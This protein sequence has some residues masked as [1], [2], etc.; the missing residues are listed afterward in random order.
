[1]NAPTLALLTRGL[2]VDSRAIWPYV[3]RSL[4]L[5]GITMS[6]LL[7]A[8]RM[9]YVSAAG[10]YFLTSVVYFTFV[11]VSLTAG[12]SFATLLT[13]E[14]EENTLGLLKMAGLGPLAI[15]LGKAGSSGAGAVI[16]LTSQFPF[17]LLAVTLGGVSLNQVV[18]VYVALLAYGVFLIGLGL[19]CSA[20]CRRSS[21]A[22]A[23]TIIFLLGFF[24]LPQFGRIAVMT[25]GSWFAA[26]SILNFACGNLSDALISLSVIDRLS[27][28]LRSG[29]AGSVWQCTQVISNVVLGL[30]FF[31]LTWFTFER[32]TR[33]EHEA[34][35]A[36]SLVASKKSIFRIFGAGRAW[37]SA[38]IWKDFYFLG[39]GRL[40]LAAKFLLCCGFVA[41]VWWLMARQYGS[42]YRRFG[43]YSEQLGIVMI[44]CMLIFMYLDFTVQLSRMFSEEVKWKTLSNIMLLPMS[45]RQIARRKFL[46]MLISEIPYVV[47]LIF[48]IA[49]HPGN[50]GEFLN[51]AAP[52]I[53][54]WTGV[55]IAIF[56]LYLV[57][58]FSLLVK[59][60]AIPLAVL[61]MFV[62]YGLTLV[63]FMIPVIIFGARSI[64]GNTVAWIL[65][66]MT[67]LLTIVLH[68]LLLRRID[69]LA[70][71]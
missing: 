10:L 49:I 53:G 15:L 11:F 69:K 59:L 28:I 26:H 12:T 3:L 5:V 4:L 22:G 65:C 56:F 43:N 54:F 71:E 38:L 37:R 46:G 63:A 34:A 40:M 21:G 8:S 42:Y 2:R 19:F 20:V 6:L 68:R 31:G 58:Y 39:G 66:A 57:A 35:P 30:F 14:K 48:G 44:V 18:A 33:E 9:V 55:A 27:T 62:L 32:F 23:M 17:T 45:T 70:G 52:E 7:A 24:V 61:T 29:F 36:R 64:D 60:G 16:L 25:S 41:L 47:V 67:V 51:N 1:M 13:S 50:V